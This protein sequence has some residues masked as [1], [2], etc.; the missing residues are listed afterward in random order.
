MSELIITFGKTHKGKSVEDLIITEPLY[1]KWLLSQAWL[2]TKYLDIYNFLTKNLTKEQ[3]M[4]FG[5][6]KN[7]TIEEIR[8]LDPKYIEWLKKND[9]VKENLKDIYELL[10]LP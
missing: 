4:P 6:Y 8:K 7:K 1:C 3:I 5:K 9:F 10:Y 2:E